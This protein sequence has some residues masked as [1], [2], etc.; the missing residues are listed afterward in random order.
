MWCDIKAPSKLLHSLQ[1]PPRCS[2]AMAVMILNQ[3]LCDFLILNVVHSWNIISE[4]KWRSAPPATSVEASPSSAAETADA[5]SA[6]SLQQH[7]SLKMKEKVRKN[8]RKKPS[9]EVIWLNPLARKE[10]PVLTIKRFIPAHCLKALHPKWT[11]YFGL[12]FAVRCCFLSSCC[13]WY[14]NVCKSCYNEVK[15]Y[16]NSFILNLVNWKLDVSSSSF[17][18]QSLERNRRFRGWLLPATSDFLDGKLTCL[19][20]CWLDGELLRPS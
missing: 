6:P 15:K 16:C 20:L 10:A 8:K 18:L 13:H 17:H 9:A 4:Q 12:G 3:I 11:E 14:P 2:T 7:V 1:Q 5:I 19:S